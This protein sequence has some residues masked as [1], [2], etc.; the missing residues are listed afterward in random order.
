[1]LWEKT[2]LVMNLTDPLVQKVITNLCEENQIKVL[3]LDNLSCLFSGMKENDA[4]AWEMV[5]N[6]LLELR[7][8]K[9]AVIIIHHSGHS[10]EHMRGTSK[11]EDA[12]FWIIN[13][14]E[15][16][17]RAPDHQGASFETSFTKQ[18]NSA[19][20]EWPRRWTVR[21][22]ADGTVSYNSEPISFDER[23]LEAIVNRVE[24]TSARLAELLKVSKDTVQR[25][26]NRLEDK[27]LVER[28]GNGPSTYYE[29]RGVLRYVK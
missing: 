19:N 11:R 7:R 25:A 3:L 6:W 1:L 10:G 4:D 15:T 27:K 20:T 8:R 23:V 9:I 5:L 24:H 28:K 17:D 26:L 18:R 14:K 21:T 13:V 29:P 12:A 16:N 22:E 2:G